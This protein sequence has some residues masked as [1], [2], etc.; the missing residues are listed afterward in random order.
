MSKVNPTIEQ[1]E[2]ACFR[3]LTGNEGV[4]FSQYQ[5]HDRV[6]ALFDI[7][8]PHEKEHFK[9]SFMMV[10]RCIP[11]IFE[12]INYT[13]SN[14]IIYLS[15]CSDNSIKIKEPETYTETETKKDNIEVFEKDDMPKDIQVVY[16]ILDNPNLKDYLNKKDGNGNTLLHSLVINND[17]EVIKKHFDKLEKFLFTK[18]NEGNTPFDYIKDSRINTIF[19]VKMLNHISLLE[20]KNEINRNKIIKLERLESTNS[21]LSKFIIFVMIIF[22]G[23]KMINLV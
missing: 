21:L 7:K 11:N 12:C 8:D 18:N 19:I 5:I 20:Q 14:D 23:N 4:R 1:I 17:Y 6:L 10:L 22:F 3:V 2:N 9:F 16:F 13:I 15:Y